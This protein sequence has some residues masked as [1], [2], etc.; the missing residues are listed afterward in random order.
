MRRAALT[1]L[2]SIYGCFP[3]QAL[4]QESPAPPPAAPKPPSTGPDGSLGAPIVAGEPPSADE[5]AT[6]IAAITNHPAGLT[7]AEAARRARTTSPA[8]RGKRAGVAAAAA[9]RDTA[10]VGLLPRLTLTARYT[11]LSPID[12]PSFGPSEGSLV[13]TPVAE[14]PLPANAL[15]VAVP[16]SALSFPVLL[17]QYLLQTNL[18][19]PVTDM[20][21]RAMSQHAAAAHDEEAATIE[22]DVAARATAANARLA[23]WGWVRA[24]M[25]GEVAKQTLAQAR[26]HR[27]AAKILASVSRAST[28]DVLAADAQVARAELAVE[29]ARSAS[30]SA[31]QRLRRLMHEEQ[32]VPA[33]GYTIGEDV[34]GTAERAALPKLRELYAEAMRLRPE[35]RIIDQRRRATRSR[36]QAAAAGT[37]PRLDLFANAYVANPNQRYVPQ[38]EEW[39]ASWDAGVQLSWSPNDLLGSG[40]TATSIDAR[41]AQLD[42]ERSDRE[43]A[44]AHEVREAYYA[45][46]QARAAVV[47][48][49]RVV[50]AA[51][52]AYRARGLM[53]RYGKASAVAVVDS[54]AELLRARLE[55]IDA[56]VG[57]RAAQVRLD[58]ALGRP[59]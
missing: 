2:L 29:H 56:L 52:E 41:A 28:G 22:V 39:R 34:Q 19:V 23:Y 54:E 14:G 12:A 40:S 25:Q 55:R 17:N 5:L 16:S 32:E 4:A 18:T 59:L 48:T 1:A 3:A 10:L 6:R 31:V 51:E 20:A 11:R 27:H 58:H 24:R 42:A 50:A 46:E 44:I 15:L 57:V 9:D 33:Q 35:L 21:L 37:L 30:E 49:R 47:A 7:A 38:A 13:A 45:L 36:S 53:F 26:A 8:L 43:D